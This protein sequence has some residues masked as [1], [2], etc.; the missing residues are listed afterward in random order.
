MLPIAYLVDLKVL[1]YGVEA[2]VQIV[3]K[4]DDLHRRGASGKRSE[5]NDVAKVDGHHLVALWSHG[6]ATQ[7]LTGHRSASRG[8]KENRSD[9]EIIK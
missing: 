4:V 6:R 9:R 3:E 2:C 5:A 1:D 7:Q 8:G